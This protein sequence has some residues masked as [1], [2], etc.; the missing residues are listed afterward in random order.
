MRIV[1]AAGLSLLLGLSLPAQAGSR[2][3]H[4]DRMVSFDERGSSP[5]DCSALEVTL[6]GKKVEVQEERIAIPAGEI[7]NVRVR[8]HGGLYVQPGSGSGYTARLCK[9]AKDA[10][11]L[12]SI[13]PSLDGRSL[14]VNGP[15]SD[16][17]WVAYLIVDAP[18]DASM[19]LES[20]NA[21]ISLKRVRG[22]FVAKATNGPISIEDTEGTIDAATQNGPIALTGSQ[23][24][25]KL[26][27]RNGPIA[28]ELQ[29]EWR[30]KGL[31][32]RT[33]NGP[34]ALTVSSS[35]RSGVVVESE[36]HSPFACDGPS[37]DGWKIDGHGRG[38][39]YTLGTSPALVRLSTSNGPV[40]I[41]SPEQ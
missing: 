40:A 29:H 12:P 21:P 14:T 28:V 17:D 26:R 22:S 6:D 38:R 31:D 7:L 8:E 34:V 16:D 27:A 19:S 24:D 13:R 18:A 37:C 15:T 32:A 1:V 25:V 39:T 30:G 20:D 36:G 4:S 35:F 2:H 23:G 10:S 41:S 5:L 3:R 11:E 33:E 9:A